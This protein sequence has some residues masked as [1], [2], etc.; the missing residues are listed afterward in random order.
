MGAENKVGELHFQEFLDEITELDLDP[1]IQSWYTV[2]VTAMLGDVD[3]LYHE[4]NDE[5]G[6]S[7]LFLPKSI[8]HFC[9]NDRKMQ[10]YPKHLVHCFVDHELPKKQNLHSTENKS[11]FSAEMFS[12]SPSDEHLNWSI[13]AHSENEVPQLQ[14][15]TARWLRYLNT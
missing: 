6:C 9:P 8:I 10:H 2:D 7:L 11:V 3:I 13:C 14:A 15:R 4:I 12:I 5:N 1:R